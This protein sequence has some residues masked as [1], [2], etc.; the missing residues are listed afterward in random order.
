MSNTKYSPRQ[1]LN[2]ESGSA[3]IWAIFWSMIFLVMAGLSIDVSNAHRMRSVLMA[4]ADSASVGAM[5]AYRERDYYHTYT[6]SSLDMT[7]TQRARAVANGLTE[8]MMPASRHGDVLVDADIEPGHWDGDRFLSTGTVNAVR[9]TTKRTVAG[10]NPVMTTLLGLFGGLQSWNVGAVSVA[11]AYYPECFQKQGIIAQGTVDLATQTEVIDYTCIHGQVAVDMQ[12]M[13][14]FGPDAVVSA[15]SDEQL[16]GVTDNISGIFA[17]NP[18]LEDAWTNQHLRPAILDE[19]DA[20]VATVSDPDT[21]HAEDVAEYLPAYV[22]RAGDGTYSGN[23]TVYNNLT[24][25][26]TAV[27]ARRRG[28]LD[29]QPLDPGTIHIVNCAPSDLMELNR[30]QTFHEVVLVTNCRIQFSNAFT[31]SHSLIISTD[32]TG[33]TTTGV[34]ETEWAVTGSAGTRIGAGT[35]SDDLGSQ[36]MAAGD[37]RFAASLSLMKSQIISKTDVH[38]AADYDGLNGSYV[39]SGG[40]VS[41]AS[42]GSVGTCPDYDPTI[43]FVAEHYRIVQ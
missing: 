31:F 3:T 28:T 12:T 15:P 9:V 4:S 32:T 10:G 30:A 7:P 35:C 16:I 26:E 27:T 20:I 34:T 21:A 33:A 13:N 39:V 37:V 14:N 42:L 40:D 25:F 36:L 22:Q 2:D 41:V 11:E 38:I 24:A 19:F 17:A 23:T 29:P 5:M 6:G 1:F 18:G 8:T 43:G